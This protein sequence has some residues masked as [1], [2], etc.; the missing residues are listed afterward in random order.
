MQPPNIRLVHEV[1]AVQNVLIDF[2]FKPTELEVQFAKHTH[3]PTANLVCVVVSTQN[4]RVPIN[5]GSLDGLSKEEFLAGFRAWI[6]QLAKPAPAGENREQ[7]LR[8]LY[9]TTDAYK[10]RAALHNYLKACGLHLLD[11]Q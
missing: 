6:E 1:W 11:V 9:Q 3:S 8:A 10:D 5:C 2:G 4:K 7:V